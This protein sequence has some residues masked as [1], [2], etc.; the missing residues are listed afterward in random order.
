MQDPKPLSRYC[1]KHK[2]T[3]IIVEGL[4]VDWN[5]E[6]YRNQAYAEQLFDG[7]DGG[8]MTTEQAFFQQ[9]LPDD[10]QHAMGFDAF[11]A[12][13]ISETATTSSVSA[14]AADAQSQRPTPSA[15]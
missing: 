4:A 3:L 5:S 11:S 8:Q 15:Q 13:S 2:K 1:C 14:V 7:F 10:N 12:A 6:A 9:F